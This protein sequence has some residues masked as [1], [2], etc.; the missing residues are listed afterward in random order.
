[1]CRLQ[2]I[3]D[4]CVYLVRDVLEAIDNILEVIVELG[5]DDKAHCIA[6]CV[7]L[8][9]GKEEPLSA[10]LVE[11]VR[12]LL[13]VNDFLGERVELTGVIAD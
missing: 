5:P 8:P 12:M 7:S 9:I 1:M 2:V 4:E 13:D 6:L 3:D 10:Q 11:L